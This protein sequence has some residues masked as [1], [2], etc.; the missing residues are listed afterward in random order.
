LE[1]DFA[2]IRVNAFFHGA[3]FDWAVANPQPVRSFCM[4]TH[5]GAKREPLA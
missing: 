5:A 4:D 1:N 3:S 2:V